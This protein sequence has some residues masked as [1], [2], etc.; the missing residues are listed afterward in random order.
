MSIG[1][2]Q[3]CARAECQTKFT[4]ST[5]NQKYCSGECCRLETNRKIMEKYHER[6]AIRKGKKRTCLTCLTPLSRYNNS[7]KCGGCQEKVRKENVG[8][9]AGIV[10]S[11]VWL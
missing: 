4:K 6:V 5:H 8:E 9:A 2:T 10:K 7:D 1:N 3:V 11:V